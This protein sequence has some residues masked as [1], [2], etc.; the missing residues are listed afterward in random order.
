MAETAPERAVLV[1]V[2]LPDR[3]PTHTAE[4]LDELAALADSAG[5][6]VVDRVSQ[7]RRSLD[8]ATYI[9]SGKAAELRE[10]V[11]ELGANLV[12][13]D[14]ELRPSQQRNLEEALGVKTLD[15]TQLILDVFANRAATSEG[16]LQVE[17]AQLSYLLP[18]LIGFG[19]VLSRLGGGIGTRGPG[20]TKLEVDRRRLRDRIAQLRRELELVSRARGMQRQAR[21]RG[22]AHSIA[23]AGYTNA[24]KS[25]LFN[26]M[27]GAKVVVQDRL[28]A[29]LDPTV[30]PLADIEA[31]GT[32]LL[33]VDT[34]GFIRKLPHSLVAAFRATLEEVAEADLVLRVVD[35]ASPLWREQLSTVD[36]VLDEI[37]GL[38]APKGSEASP[39]WLVFNKCDLLTER[40]RRELH[41]EYPQA[42]MVSATQGEGLDAMKGGLQEHFE[43]Q[44][45]VERYLLPNDQAYLLKRH[46]DKLRV[47][48]E[49]WGPKGLRV[50]LVLAQ[51]VAELEPFRLKGGQ[52][53]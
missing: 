39:R 46:W 15:R 42:W 5:A 36:G 51:P 9:G 48:D 8:P 14:D 35:A 28:F 30:R 31:A 6:A 27:T 11:L 44:L 4:S 19:A 47:L 3:D 41:G 20:E 43:S 52:A 32:P 26:A 38:Y 53:A 29:T 37:Q 33:A 1:G 13:F 12:I 49:R 34:V 22:R 7:A 21:K 18:R 16:K 40:S 25:T 10:R 45:R 24:G 23:L 17:L 50:E 2:S